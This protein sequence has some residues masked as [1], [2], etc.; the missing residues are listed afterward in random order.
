MSNNTNK[1]KHVKVIIRTRP[2]SAFVQ[3][4]I[5]FGE[6]KKSVHIHIPKNEEWGYI[7]NQQE[8]WDFKFDK[9]LHNASQ[10]T[11]Y[12]ECGVPVI[13]SVLNGYNAT[14]LAYGQTGAGKTFTMTGASENYK[15]RGI[16]PRAITHLFREIDDQVNLAFTVRISYME[17][18]NEQIIDLLATL[19]EENTVTGDMLTVVE[20]KNNSTH[21]KGLTVKIANNE[22]EALNLLFE[23]ETNRSI[24]EH[25]LNRNSSRSHCIFTIHVESRSRVESSEKVLTAKLNLVDLAGSE[26]LSKT[27]TKGITLKEAMYINRSLTYLEQVIIALA[28]KKRDHIPFRQ[29]KMTHV[30]R[31]ALG[32]NCNTLMIANIWGQKEHIE[33]TIST[34]RFATRMMCVSLSPEVNI[35]YDPLALIKKYEKEIKELKQELS[36]HDTL[37]NRSHVQYEAYTEAQRAELIKQIKNY[38]DNEMEEPEIIN[39]RH[40]REMLI[41]FRLLYKNLEGEYENGQRNKISNVT[42]TGDAN[43]EGSSQIRKPGAPELERD[44]G[45]VGDVEGAG[46]GVGVAPLGKNTRNSAIPFPKPPIQKKKV[47]HYEDEEQS[48]EQPE[49]QDQYVQQ[50]GG[51]SNF[52]RKTPL[53]RAEEFE[54]FKR[55]ILKTKK[56]QAKELAENVNDIK[57]Q[58]DELKEKLGTKKITANDDNQEEYNNI[59]HLKKLKEDYKKMYEA[60]KPLRS[61]IEYCYRLTDQCR[62]KLMTEFEQWYDSSFGPM[63]SEQTKNSDD[64]LDIGEKFDRLQMERMSLEDPDS[65]PFYNAKKNSDRRNVRA[66]KRGLAPVKIAAPKAK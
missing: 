56:K 62:Q 43:R 5:Q 60:L 65:L 54:V 59:S 17:I 7:N 34:L 63:Q 53:S 57:R 38:I 44:E 11:M 64:V 6:D 23:G 32:G 14:V 24:A 45:G 18:Y 47:A 35:Q 12:E 10:E 39:I 41:V 30:L 19:N 66:V 21:V 25:Q 13:K 8:N 15:H 42:P 27:E 52:A 22:E 55:M 48:A 33:E 61:D 4:L 46:F 31:D 9:I 58:I 26:R 1:S 50:A 20:D 16:I 3:D 49:D 40:I 36:M 28:D 2:T 51:S 37:A 29:S